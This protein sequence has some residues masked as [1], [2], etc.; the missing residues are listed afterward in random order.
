MT[1]LVWQEAYGRR[2]SLIAELIFSPIIG[3]GGYGRNR[4]IFREARVIE[5]APGVAGGVLTP[6]LI[7]C[8]D[9]VVRNIPEWPPAVQR[10]YFLMAGSGW[11]G[12]DMIR[13]Q[14]SAP[15]SAS[16]AIK[17]VPFTVLQ[18]QSQQSL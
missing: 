13:N 18:L 1:H 11:M 3:G 4:G 9:P 14:V 10:P 6:R 15:L 16:A 7:S 8:R 5:D 12:R 17:T 2:G